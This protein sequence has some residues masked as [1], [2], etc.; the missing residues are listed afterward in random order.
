MNIVRAILPITIIV[1]PAAA[2]IALVT[3]TVLISSE[4][5]LTSLE[6]TLLQ[7]LIV[8]TSVSSSYL[9][10][11]K[12]AKMA[13]KPHARSAFLR[14]TSLYSGLFYIKRNI[15]RHRL[16]GSRVASEVVAII[17]A[18]VDQQVNTAEHALQDWR[19]IIPEE[20][21][22]FEEKLRESS[23]DELEDLRR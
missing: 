13:A 22:D 18:A 5:S 1:I 21:A 20:V 16:S 12:A 15:D 6:A 8:I 9:F 4:R 19:E 2:C 23:R 3:V 11:Q 14:V 17:E 10:S 7:I